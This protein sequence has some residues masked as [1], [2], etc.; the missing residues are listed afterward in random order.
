MD[1]KRIGF[2]KLVETIGKNFF[3]LH[4]ETA[5]FSYGEEDI[6]LYCFLGIDLHP[7][8][9]KLCL[10]CDIDEWDVYASCYVTDTNVLI[11]KCKLP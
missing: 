3:E 7:E 2:N 9:R 10:S 5:L 8:L 6:G 4:K 1:K 11:D